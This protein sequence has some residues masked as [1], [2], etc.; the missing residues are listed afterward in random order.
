M[1]LCRQLIKPDFYKTAIGDYWCS[2]QFLDVIWS[3]QQKLSFTWIVNAQFASFAMFAFDIGS[4]Q[5]L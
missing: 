1:Y 2:V 3:I 4:T 5:N